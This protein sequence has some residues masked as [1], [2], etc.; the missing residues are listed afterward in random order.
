[1][2]FS[3]I[4][5]SPGAEETLVPALMSKE[6]DAIAKESPTGG[7][8]TVFPILVAIGFYHF[9]NDMMQSLNPAMYPLLKTGSQLNFA[10]VGLIIK[11]LDV[12]P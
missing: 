10:Q 5:I 8:Q 7:Q 12:R 3:K 2:L 6:N 9:L 11:R 1:M 4:E